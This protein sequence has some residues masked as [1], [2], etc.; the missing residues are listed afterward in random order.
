MYNIRQFKPA[1]YVLLL[2]GIIGFSL[3]AE[4]PGIWVLGTAG[5]LL[6]GWLV[7]TGRFRPLP[8]LLANL[9]TIGATL[10]IVHEAMAPSVTMVM[11]IGKFLVLLQLIKL[12]EQ[13]ANRDFAQLLI[14][15]LLLMV[16]A[17]INTASL[18]FGVL[19]VLYLF[20]SLY[21]CLL[22]H[23]KVESDNARAAFAVPA[24]KV[25]PATL[26]Q[27]ETYLSR[28]MRRLTAFVA[29]IAIVMAV[30]VF[31]LFPRGAGAGMFG[32]LQFRA[33][34]TLTGFSDN[35]SFQQL[36]K[37]TQ[38]NEEVAYVSVVRN[39]VPLRGTETLLLRGV[40]LDFYNTRPS[41][42]G[43]PWEW[44][45]GLG[46]DEQLVVADRGQNAPL[47]NAAAPPEADRYIQHITLR[48]T[49]TRTLFAIAGAYSF[50]PR[51][52]VKLKYT[53]GDGVLQTE[54]SMTQP[55]EYEVI[56]SNLLPRDRPPTYTQE[57]RR[58]ARMA[59]GSTR[60]YDYARRP[61]VSGVSA[62]G[63]PLS[64]QRPREDYS[65]P[66]DAQIARNIEDHL[67]R[68]FTYTLD[69]TDA[70]RLH[71]DED[72]MEKFLY[73]LK[74]GHCEYFAGAMTLMCQSLGIQARVVNGFKCDEFNELGEYYIVRQSHAHSWVEVL[75]D[76]DVWKTFDPTSSR[77]DQRSDAGWWQRVRHFFDY[78]E[79]SYANSV[80]AYDNDHR[81]NLISH[82]ETQMTNSSYAGSDW[83]RRVRA[84]FELNIYQVSST[85]IGLMMTLMILA[86][87]AFV[88]W[89]FWE[90]WMLRRRAA[91]IGLES[92]PPSDQLRLVRQLGFYDEL[93]RLLARHQITRP[94]HL[95]PLEFSQTL[96]YLPNRAFDTI[97][98]LTEVFYRVRYGGAELSHGMQRRLGTAIEQL[99][100]SMGSPPRSR[101]V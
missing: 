64:E 26:R 73:E 67:K 90:R 70:A 62:D 14:L 69:L 77:E 45:R 89:F 19:L 3:A 21:C 75:T 83:L 30:V 54:E 56:S 44:T 98:R 81:E 41:M 9:I 101:G 29:G 60:V 66:L 11:V 36:A 31:V 58:R 79:F 20:L 86:M 55:L 74:R 1:L 34:Q 28:S 32:P 80:I 12:W 52:D 85:A 61:D 18:M 84:W 48:P 99:G 5:I 72:P 17:S 76:N 71:R 53:P 95:T 35:V 97:L 37:I 15:S 6:N 40:T 46:R 88:V 82:V 96:S 92:L 7:S 13:R 63:K 49:G 59:R 47:P 78:L 50:S 87:I 10:F 57:E 25:S 51:R 38:S 43:G 94:K 27:D 33:S 42:R 2:V 16:A 22:F 24:D 93:V 100:E 4:A 68:T 8:R 65:H 39:G 91:R 23:L